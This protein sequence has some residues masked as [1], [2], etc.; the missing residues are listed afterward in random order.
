MVGI[1]CFLA[2]WY[3]QMSCL[4]NCLQ[5]PWFPIHQFN[6]QIKDH[7]TEKAEQSGKYWIHGKIC[8]KISAGTSPSSSEQE[9][10]SETSPKEIWKKFSNTPGERNFFEK[11]LRNCQ[12]DFEL[13]E[14]MKSPSAQ[15]NPAVNCLLLSSEYSHPIAV[16]PGRF[17]N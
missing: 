7:E 17:K 16:S 11:H 8:K 3:L 5:L 12:T 1:R 15:Q 9:R 10:K 4:L 13:G 6:P 2:W 14:V